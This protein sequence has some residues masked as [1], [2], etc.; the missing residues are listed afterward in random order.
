M[1]IVRQNRVARFPTRFS[2]VAA[3][4]PCPVRA[5]RA[6]LPLRRGGPPAARAPA[7]RPAAGPHRPR[8]RRRAAEHRGPRCGA[9]HDVGGGAR[10]GAR[11]ARA[12]GRPRACAAT[13]SFAARACAR[14]RRSPRRRASCWIASTTTATCPPAAAT[15]RCAWRE[16]SPTSTAPARVDAAHLRVALAYRRQDEALA[17]VG[18]MSTID[19]CDDCARRSWLVAR[20][21]GHLE[22]RR[23]ER[24]GIRE[25]LA[26][27]GR[28]ADRRARRA[29]GRRDRGRARRPV[30]RTSCGRRGLR[31][32]RTRSAG[33]GP[34]I[35]AGLLDLPD[36][37][38][39]LHLRGD[40]QPAAPTCSPARRS[41]SSARARR[42]PEAR[43]CAR[44]LGRGLS[45]AGVTVVSGMALGIDSAAH[46]GALE[47]ARE[48]DRRA[49]LRAGRP[50]PAQP[51]RA[52]RATRRA[53][54]GDL[55]ASA[56][57]R[58]H[59]AGGS[60][61]ATG[62]SRRSRR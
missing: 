41:R 24:E 38:A 6:G 17:R 11:G 7:V 10:T 32:A 48:H 4:N 27:L 26:L 34:A 18:G 30:T 58:R 50:L 21:S 60:P 46:E 53:G 36:A 57:A 3:T 45:A 20:L 44:L 42:P 51:P 5:R 37:P 61:R 54:G 59:T 22:L 55:R 8:G 16:R 9:G 2:L 29:R 23:A 19:V 28:A 62:S 1:S 49:R 14:P 52:A 25:V 33:T 39:V 31:P 12:A 15:G 35:P 43:D 40:P 47:A 13:P 56:R